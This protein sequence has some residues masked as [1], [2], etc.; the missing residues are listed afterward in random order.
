[1]IG[2]NQSNTTGYSNFKWF[3]G[4]KLIKSDLGEIDTR[5]FWKANRRKT[6]IKSLEKDKNK[7]RKRCSHVGKNNK[8]HIHGASQQP[9]WK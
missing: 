6:E 1:V 8:C 4:T 5:T 2:T 3:P 7:C 9:T